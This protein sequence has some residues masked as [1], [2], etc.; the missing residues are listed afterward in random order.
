MSQYQ[1]MTST[2]PFTEKT[3]FNRI[4]AKFGS[5]QKKSNFS[6]WTFVAL[7]RLELVVILGIRIVGVGLTF[8]P[9]VVLGRLISFAENSAARNAPWWHGVFYACAM[10]LASFLA[11]LMESHCFFS[12]RTIGFRIKSVVSVL[13]AEKLFRMSS[14]QHQAKLGLISNLMGGEGE[15]FSNLLAEVAAVVTAPIQILFTFV[16]ICQ[17]LGPVALIGLVPFFLAYPVVQR[18]SHVAGDHVREASKV[19]D[20]RYSAISELV[21]NIK[22][23]KLMTWERPFLDRIG[24][25][26]DRECHWLVKRILF[27]S[28]NLFVFQ[29]IPQIVGLV[30]FSVFIAVGGV[31][32]AKK[33]FVT[34]SALAVLSGTFAKTQK[35]IAFI[36]MVR[37][38]TWVR[39]V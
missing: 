7:Y 34:I 2:K 6:F 29:T 25:M 14:G 15:Q 5:S 38:G 39:L 17:Q 11:R 20:S 22:L 9:P 31:M 21:A 36:F 12:L 35:A 26:R 4:G 37:N 1:K 23:V 32:D 16:I 30:C 3:Q 33:A 18:F 10:V 13:M 8:V 19:G 27:T 28:F 24:A